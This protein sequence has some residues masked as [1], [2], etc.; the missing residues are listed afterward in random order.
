MF[1]WCYFLAW[2]ILE[3]NYFRE[4]KGEDVQELNSTFA[5]LGTA[6][7]EHELCFLQV[8][9]AYNLLLLEVIE[10]VTTMK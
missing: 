7:T 3:N 9:A 5:Q 2:V 8:R 4:D 10:D 1:I 6:P